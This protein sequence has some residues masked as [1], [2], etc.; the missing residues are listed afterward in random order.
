VL[1]VRVPPLRERVEDLPLLVD[2]LE[3]SLRR[4]VP[5]GHVAPALLERLARYA[6]PGNVRELRNVVGRALSLGTEA[7]DAWP[8][9]GQ[10]A[11]T[12]AAPA[13]LDGDSLPPFHEARASIL[14]SFE[15]DYLARLLEECDGN[16]S[17]AARRAGLHR[18]YV[19][20][21]KAKHGLGD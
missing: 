18:N 20:R 6:W 15:R 8:G 1:R 17:E 16:V 19:A 2:E 5:G 9:G 7:V 11:E 14:E 4:H 21:L 13:S 10:Q 12:A 3:R